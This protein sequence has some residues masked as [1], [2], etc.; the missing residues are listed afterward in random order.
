MIITVK[1][2]QQQTFTIDFDPEK[3]VLELK[4]QI[5]NERGV[6]YIVEKQKLIY[7]GVILTDDRTINSYKV[8]EKKFIVVMLTRDISGGGNNSTA[9]GSSAPQQK[10]IDEDAGKKSTEIPVTTTDN[11][12]TDKKP[13]TKEG[14]PL[15][16]RKTSDKT[17]EAQ[18]SSAEASAPAVGDDAAQRPY[19]SNDL[20]GELANASLQSR[21]ESNLL[22]GEEYSRT[23]A[24]M[25]EMGYP[26]E[27]VERA[28][29]ASFNNPERAVEY[30]ITGIPEEEDSFNPGAVDEPTRAADLRNALR[31]IDP[32]GEPSGDA[33]ADP[34]EFLRSQPQFLQMRSLI[35]QNPHLLHAVLQQIGQTNPA[36]L[37]LI[38]ENQDAFLNMLNQPL[39]GE[40]GGNA[41]R[42]AR[43]QAAPRRIENLVA[44]SLADAGAQRTAAGGEQQSGG[45]ATAEREGAST[46]A[47]DRESAA[48]PEGMPTIRLTTQDQDAIERLKALG[49]PEALVLQAYF[50]CEK[51]E[52]LAAN[53]LLSSSFDD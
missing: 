16:E 2:L 37:H 8:D 50:A 12:Q 11:P 19:S 28:M 45:S 32:T 40:A 26:R 13:D 25:V 24:S 34:F 5:Y 27:Q 41:Q 48:Q 44:S 39:E 53:F 7:A 33:S 36:L 9:S 21:P 1:N 6:E 43:T 51:D 49:F 35:Y 29:A 23:V 52:E 31:D 4:K 15:A 20:V 17:S 18:A 30:L 38:S 10:Q 3:T 22:V 46:G 42:A 14:E 47:A